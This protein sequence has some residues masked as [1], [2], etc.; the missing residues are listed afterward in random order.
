MVFWW[1]LLPAVKGNNVRTEGLT[2]VELTPDQDSLLITFQ[3][4]WDNSWRDD[5]NWDAV[6]LFVKC[7]KRD[8]GGMTND[9]WHLVL[10]KQQ[11]GTSN[12]ELHPGN[13]GDNVVGVFAVPKNKGHFNFAGERITLRA[14][15][16]G[17]SV[18]DLL[19]ERYFFTVT[20]IEMVWIPDASYYLGD[21]RSFHTFRSLVSTTIKPEDDIIGTNPA[22][23][24]SAVPDIYY[25]DFSPAKAADRQDNPWW[26]NGKQNMWYCG[27]T[28]VLSVAE[29]TSNV[30]WIVNFGTPKTI[31]T[32]GVSFGAEYMRSSSTF[33]AP[34]KNWYLEGSLDSLH[35]VTVSTMTPS[36]AS[37]TEHSYPVR[38]MI[39]V[40]DPGAYPYYRL[41][42]EQVTKG[43]DACEIA[44][45]AMSEEDL[46]EKY[47]GPYYV[48]WEGE[49]TFGTGLDELYS[50]DGTES[51]TLP[52]EYPKGLNGFYCMKYEVS[53]EQYVNF[54]NM[55]T[56][57][58]QKNRIGNN[59]DVLTKG[60]YVFGN[61]HMPDMRNGIIVFDKQPGRPVKFANNLNPALPYF[62]QDDGQTLPCNYLTPEDMLA[63][64]DWA[65]LRPLSEMEYEKACRKPELVRAGEYAWNTTG[66]SRLNGGGEVSGLGTSLEQ[67]V[68]A[69]RNVNAGN[70]S[71]G[72]IR[73]GG[74]AGS[75]TTQE[76]AGATFYGVMEMSGNLAEMYYSINGGSGFV[77]L[78]EDNL[79]HGDGELNFDG[80]HTMDDYWPDASAGDVFIARGGSFAGA[81]TLLRISDRSRYIPAGL[82]DGTV[83]FRGGRTMKWR[84]L[85]DDGGALT[86]ED[87]KTIA[88][89]GEPVTLR[90]DEVTDPA[91]L[92]TVYV[93]WVN[94][95]D[96]GWRR[97]PGENGKDLT[98]SG[99]E[100]VAGKSVKYQFQRDAITSEGVIYQSAELT[101]PNPGIG[102]NDWEVVLDPCPSASMG[103]YASQLGGTF[104]WTYGPSHNP[105]TLGVTY[106]ST[107]TENS[108]VYTPELSHFPNIPSGGTTIDIT[109]THTLEGCVVKS[110]GKVHI[111]A[112]SDICPA[113]TPPDANG[114]VYNAGILLGCRCWMRENINVGTYVEATANASVY[115]TPGIQKLCYGNDV[116]YCASYGGLYNWNEAVSG[117]LI[118]DIKYVNGDPGQ[119][120]QGICPD[121]WHIPDAGEWNAMVNEC[122]TN[123]S[124]GLKNVDDWWGSSSPGT[125]STGMNMPGG[126]LLNGNTFQDVGKYGMWWTS[127]AINAS[128]ASRR[129]MTY[130]NYAVT[131]TTMAKSYGYSVRCVKN[132]KQ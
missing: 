48:F 17:I 34:T 126:G 21:N 70:P 120:I 68:S 116:S 90:G 101:V 2:Q 8:L 9:W 132:T 117:G 72:P 51:G 110:V 109:C 50:K 93:W 18:A 79:A 49:Q 97:I 129:H 47:G 98:Y 41:Y 62:A 88:C 38:N 73:C 123:P 115:A 22:F 106:T 60:Q 95:P 46:F 31:R 14:P 128:S 107:K 77:G 87:G 32:F 100:N 74:F 78:D 15:L 13:T 80:A 82:R 26:L 43:K 94:S 96:E 35:W 3:L 4:S 54:L 1:V 86:V 102:M 27:Q 103:V 65:G 99:F 23:R 39:R 24:Y 52:L 89:P 58:Q 75:A 125:N 37:I 81:D 67:P 76:Q 36:M 7:R 66:L 44:N 16:N 108:S 71:F 30:Q 127:T 5:Y 56:Y 33:Y 45:V 121:G 119:G 85:G 64:L 20:G 40:E 111:P 112:A 131:T 104:T 118:S 114:R 92:R 11:T 69:A 61:P 28:G 55:L 6:W 84:I 12:L 113:V 105:L 42:F 29:I 91:G 63:Y 19:N 57:K 25:K 83:G 124:Q 130:N 122:G 59:P 10:G 53:Q